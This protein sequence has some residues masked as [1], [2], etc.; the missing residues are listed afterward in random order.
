MCYNGPI[1]EE[2]SMIEY[3]LNV[4]DN[5]SWVSAAG[6]LR[7]KIVGICIAPNAARNLVPWITIERTAVRDGTSTQVR[8]RMCATDSKLKMM[9]VTRLFD[10][11]S[12]TWS[13]NNTLLTF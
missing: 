9:Q 11:P 5:V 4:G 1:A 10:E 8:T 7:G 6:H 13:F 12:K 3:E 2:M